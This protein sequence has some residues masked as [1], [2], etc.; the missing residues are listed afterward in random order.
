MIAVE[1]LSVFSFQNILK[2]IY[3][4]PH[5]HS[6]FNQ[7]EKKKKRKAPPFFSFSEQTTSFLTT[8]LSHI[9]RP[10][11]ILSGITESLLDFLPQK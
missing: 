10:T 2:S 11:G 4:F 7:E 3:Y 9:Q 1:G 6:I 5:E 8:V